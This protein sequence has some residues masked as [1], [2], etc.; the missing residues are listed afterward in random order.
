M[1]VVVV[2]RTWQNHGVLT[3][4]ILANGEDLLCFALIG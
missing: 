2:E 3:V 4:G 1:S